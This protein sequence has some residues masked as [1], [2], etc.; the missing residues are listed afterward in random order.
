MLSLVG[1]INADNPNVLDVNDDDNLFLPPPAMS[2]ARSS[3]NRAGR[4][5]VAG[6]DRVRTLTTRRANR[7]VSRSTSKGPRGA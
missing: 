6:G 1:A 5:R 3:V 2:A 4:S 7:S